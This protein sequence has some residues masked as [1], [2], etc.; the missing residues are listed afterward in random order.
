MDVLGRS[1]SVLN[2]F[3]TVKN[4]V[5][6]DTHPALDDILE[7]YRSRQL[8][9]QQMQLELRRV[10]GRNVLRQAL[11]SMV[12]DIDQQLWKRELRRA[13]LGDDITALQKAVDAAVK[14]KVDNDSI[15]GDRC[16]GP[17][18]AAGPLVGLLR[19]WR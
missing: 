14:A 8:G 11:L 16:C 6:P 10:A 17:G 1:L 12:P 7:R 4:Y 15:N 2:L 18:A 9:K 3:A 19:R 13:M 5:P